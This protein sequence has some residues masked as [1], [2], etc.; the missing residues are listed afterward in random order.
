MVTVKGNG[1]DAAPPPMTRRAVATSFQTNASYFTTCVKKF[2]SHD[3]STVN[4]YIS[5][6]SGLLWKKKTTTLFDVRREITEVV[7]TNSM[8]KIDWNSTHGNKKQSFFIHRQSLTFWFDNRNWHC[9][10]KILNIFDESNFWFYSN[11]FVCV[12]SFRKRIPLDHER[13]YRF[14]KGGSEGPNEY[15]NKLV[16]A[17]LHAEYFERQSQYA[18]DLD[19]CDM[20]AMQ[21]NKKYRAA[22]MSESFHRF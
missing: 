18:H 16:I 9:H 11:F 2:Y 1:R 13:I 7:L 6:Y 5:I 10:F 8:V 21:L 12:I 20:C 17:W 3:C 4:I 15:K 14:H 22:K 19:I